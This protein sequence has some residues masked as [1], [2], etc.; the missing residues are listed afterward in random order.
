M[1]GAEALEIDDLLI[2]G[3][4]THR[5][6]PA[7]ELLKRSFDLLASAAALLLTSPILLAVSLLVRLTSKGPALFRQERIGKG[8]SL[9]Q[10][11]KFRTMVSDAERYSGPVLAIKRDPRITAL[12]RLLRATRLDELPQL[13]NV[14]KGDMSLVGPRPERAH[15]VARFEKELPAYEL[16]H[17]VKPG[18]T[19]LAQV[20]GR[21]G[22]TV[23]SKLRFDLLYIYNYSLLLDLKILLQTARVVLQHEQAAGLETVRLTGERRN[24]INASERIRHI[25][26][27][28]KST[29]SQTN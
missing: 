8:G 22:T 26:R 11:L 7:E 15:F 3:I 5:L 9:F 17:A 2:F 21:Y 18:L 25:E 24:R 28:E 16:R 20:M 10:V 27:A 4:Q 1:F 23:E 13:Y 12:G 6:D 29:N 14:I 19:G